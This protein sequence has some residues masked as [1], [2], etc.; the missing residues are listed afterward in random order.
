VNVL[1][2]APHPD[3]EVLGCGGTIHR[4]S[5]KGHKVTVAIVTRGWAP[6]FSEQQVEQVRSEAEQANKEVLG[7][8]DLRF[9]DLP[10]TGLKDLP[11]HKINS[12]FEDLVSSVQ[13]QWVFLPFGADRH[14]DHRQCFAAASVATRP[15]P[16]GPIITTI[17]CYET[18]SETHWQAPGLEPPFEPNWYVDITDHLEAKLDALR[19]YRS[20]LEQ[21]NSPK[22][23]QPEAVQALNVWRGATMGLSAAEAFAIVRHVTPQIG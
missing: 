15:K 17:A 23:R 12:V 6:L 13:P 22:A 4:L 21:G 8:A 10:V 3:D 2:V 5:S 19:C 20:Q 18:P 1:V 11:A 16:E 14:E 7:V 9:L